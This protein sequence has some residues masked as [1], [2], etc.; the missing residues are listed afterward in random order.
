MQW[1][2]LE[3]SGGRC[4]NFIVN[5]A[6]SP[7]GEGVVTKLCMLFF[8]VN[9]SYAV[10]PGANLLSVDRLLVAVLILSIVG[11]G[12]AWSF[13]THALDPSG[14]AHLSDDSGLN[15]Q[16]HD[17]G[18]CDHC[19]HAGAHLAGLRSSDFR[20]FPSVS[21]LKNATASA[22]YLTRATSPPLKP[23]QA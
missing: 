18:G 21:G 3:H 23:P 9:F 5:V 11:Y 12:T 16:D 8:W 17:D 20:D 6:P 7:L 15:P 1:P 2:C 10:H 22:V 19:C 13:D 4:S 14:H